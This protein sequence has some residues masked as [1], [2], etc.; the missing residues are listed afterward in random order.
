MLARILLAGAALPALTGCSGW[1][2]ALDTASGDAG[3][4]AWLTRLFTIVLGVIWA[5]V[6]VALFISRRGRPERG[7]QDPLSIDPGNDRRTGIVVGGLV[8][9][10]LVVVLVLTG[11]SYAG[12]RRLFGP[13]DE[14]VTIRVIG[15]QWWWEVRYES[16]DSSR[17]FTTAN[18]IHVPVGQPVNIK[19][20]S[21]DVIHSFWVPSLTGKLDAITGRENQLRFTADRPG[22]YRGQCAEFCGLQHAHMG[23]LVVAES[24][25]E[26]D[27]WRDG[28]IASA[29]QPEDGELRQGL[30]AFA[31]GPCAMCHTI[32][33]TNAGG[34]I[35]PDLTH[36][37]SRRYLA[38][39]ALPM[40]RGNLAA[41]IVDPH[42]I[43]PGVNMPTIKLSA[44]ELNSISAYLESL[45]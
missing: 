37:G 8:L 21:T 1:Q 10:S 44:D 20:N 31:A 14:A 26:F 22:I 27:R 32:R 15:H 25:E 40:S 12:Q 43:K 17:T 35:A 36:V 28:Q 24:H 3:H 19:L 18:E 41:W 16:Q 4:I 13:R 34:K 11:L 5:A 9:A 45:K 29:K 23:I 7:V 42:S 2:N 6:M 39:G 30:A 33:G 38:A